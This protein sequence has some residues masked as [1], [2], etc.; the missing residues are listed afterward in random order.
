MVA[1]GRGQDLAHLPMEEEEVRAMELTLEFHKMPLQIL[2][3]EEVAPDMTALSE[4]VG[5][6]AL[7]L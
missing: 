5:L 4:V 3:A 1:E 7:G 6:E 2:V